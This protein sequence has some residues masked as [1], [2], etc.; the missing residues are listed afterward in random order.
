[1]A[2]EKQKKF[3]MGCL[4]TVVLLIG[5]LLLM[6]FLFVVPALKERGTTGTSV[7]TD[8]AGKLFSRSANDDDIEFYNNKESLFS[9]DFQITP[10]T[11]IKDLQITFIFLDRNKNTV[12]TRNYILG[13]V[14]KGVTYSVTY[15]LQDILPTSV[16]VE[17]HVTG[18][19]VS[20]F[21]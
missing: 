3:P 2:E 10:K 8:G 1:M 17:P 6:I 18:G 21:A 13:N 9:Y 4:I 5:G 7:N 16:W 14:T 11:D 19:T 20:Y 15:G 12:M